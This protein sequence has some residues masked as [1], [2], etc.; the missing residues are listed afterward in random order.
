MSAP[1]TVSMAAKVLAALPVDRL[2]TITP[3]DFQRW[4]APKPL[5]TKVGRELISAA[6]ASRGIRTNAGTV[7][8]EGA[9][10]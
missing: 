7:R 4:P 1:W 6:R 5:P 10:K 9:K 8:P 2:T 3:A